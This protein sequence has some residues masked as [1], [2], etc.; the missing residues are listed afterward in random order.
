M[1][2]SHENLVSCL[3]FFG[4]LHSELFLD[5]L[6][7]F[8]DHHRVHLLLLEFDSLLLDFFPEFG[9]GHGAGVRQSLDAM[10]LVRDLCLAISYLTL[11]VLVGVALDEELSHP[12]GE[13][14]NRE[15]FGPLRRCVLLDKLGPSSHL[16]L[17]K[18]KHL[19]HLQGLAQLF[20]REKLLLVLVWRG[21]PKDDQWEV[22]RRDSGEIVSDE[23]HLAEV[24]F[25][26]DTVVSIL[27]TLELN[28]DVARCHVVKRPAEFVLRKVIDVEGWILPC[29][30]TVSGY[31]NGGSNLR[32]LRAEL[33]HCR[34]TR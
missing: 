34:S 18:P 4:S 24:D 6:E 30:N 28:N 13:L 12:A 1:V 19:T 7:V 29:K 22:K 20:C 10:Y 11:C 2:I 8:P 31:D 21:E 5:H 15:W 27:H 17:S 32:L 14:F 23:V 9:Q 16:R 26:R 25:E 33:V 3:G